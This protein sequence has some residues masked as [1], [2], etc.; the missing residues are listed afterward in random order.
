MDHE[1]QSAGFSKCLVS[2]W[3]L[4]SKRDGV[5]NPEFQLKGGLA[6]FRLPEV[7]QFLH[8]NRK[9]G[10]LAIYAADH[11]HIGS[12]FLVQGEL[13]HANLKEI[14]GV[15]AFERIMFLD[16]GYFIFLAE[17]ISQDL[18]IE[19][20]LQVL[21][22]EAH[23]RHDELSRFR[24]EL[25]P[26]ETVLAILNDVT[27]VP[28]LTTQEWKILSL[29]NGKRSIEGIAQ[30]DGDEHAA[31][32]ALHSLMVK[33]LIAVT[34]EKSPLLALTPRPLP[35]SRVDGERPYPPRL[36]TNLLLKAIDGRTSLAKL[37]ESLQIEISELAEDIR[38]LLELRWISFPA[39]DENAWRQYCQDPH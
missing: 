18:T 3:E 4:R 2:R 36:R 6:E 1:I 34:T 21:L 8:I 28:S 31:L 27:T 16:R 39:A 29:I 9:T 24:A 23:A 13:V 38:L 35:A 25:P 20:P 33:G 30:K 22:M 37:A 12:I 14:R 11:S 15:A 10:E 7:V 32:S 5:M 17:N 19:S 26:F